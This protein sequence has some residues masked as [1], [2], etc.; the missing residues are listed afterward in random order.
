MP[1]TMQEPPQEGR[2][3]RYLSFVVSGKV[4]DLDP[5]MTK[6]V[7]CKCGRMRISVPGGLTPLLTLCSPECDFPT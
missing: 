1:E 7:T 3:S 2:P 5:W 6:Q 4:D